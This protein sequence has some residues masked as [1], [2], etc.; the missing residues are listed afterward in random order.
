M[1]RIPTFTSLSAAVTLVIA[2][3][4]SPALSAPSPV[5]TDSPPAEPSVSEEPSAPS[6]TAE[7][8]ADVTAGWE[9]HPAA[10]LAFV[11]PASDADP[12]TQVFIVEADGSLRQVTGVSNALGASFPVWS[13][14]GE[15]IVFSGPKVGEAGI[16]GQLGV[17]NADGTGER[18][19]AQ[20]QFPQ[21]SPDGTRITF[22]EVDEVTAEERSLYIADVATGEITEIGLGTTPRWLGDGER[23]AY[24]AA[25]TAPDGAI[26]PALYVMTL[27]TG[28]SEQV[29]DLTE[30]YP[31]PDRS[32]VLLE[33]E[34]VL[35]LADGNLAAPRELVDGVDPVWS[36]DGTRFAFAY[37]FDADAN[38]VH[39]VV[40]LEGNTIVS[41]LTGARPSWSPDGTRLA[42]EVYGPESPVIQV[43]DV[44]SGQIAFEQD[45]MEPAWRP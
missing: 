6:Q 3:C 2:A 27:E 40:D 23:I 24:N 20:G 34:G 17:V 45:G 8:T 14:D 22:N 38:P 44:A 10:G 11:M 37:E 30:A 9:G 32:M 1:R 12:T 31:S 7:P 4:S 43:V 33:R 35:S 19:I 18:Q 28:E 5:L 21:W 41:G 39:A 42:L 25:T 36:P 15:R 13:P 16:F 26:I 29:A